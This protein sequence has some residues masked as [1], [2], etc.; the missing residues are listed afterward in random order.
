VA[1]GS[2]VETKLAVKQ[3]RGHWCSSLGQRGTTGLREDRGR[4]SWVRGRQGKVVDGELAQR[5]LV[6]G[7]SLHIRT[8]VGGST[9]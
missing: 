4:V 9:R 2:T 8:L 7:K 3:K 1:R 5:K 6:V